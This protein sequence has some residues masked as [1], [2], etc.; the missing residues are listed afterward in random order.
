MIRLRSIVAGK[1]ARA[2]EAVELMRSLIDMA[3]LYASKAGAVIVGVLI[4]PQF[5]RLLGPEQFGVVAVIFSLQ[6]LLLILDLGMS[7]IVGRDIAADG[8]SRQASMD[9]WRS[10]EAV[11][12]VSYAALGVVLISVASLMG[13]SLTLPQ[14]L[15]TLVL[16]WS[17]TQQNVAMSALLAKRRY[18]DAG[19]IQLVGV[20]A[21]GLGTL[22]AINVIGAS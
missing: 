3:M 18:L 7:T 19:I 22:V 17:L 4:L 12:N 6:A 16:L 14:M 10:A 2:G 13:V 15:L 1:Q 20:L 11:L 9:I 8:S 21:R 5:N